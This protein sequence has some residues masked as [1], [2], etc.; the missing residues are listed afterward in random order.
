MVF[1]AVLFLL[2]GGLIFIIILLCKQTKMFV[3]LFI[4]SRKSPMTESYLKLRVLIVGIFAFKNC[5][6]G[7]P[8]LVK[9]ILNSEW[10]NFVKFNL[11]LKILKDILKFIQKYTF[12]F[13]KIENHLKLFKNKLIEEF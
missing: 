12:A 10:I 5:L 2:L 9:I 1:S 8:T 3:Q 6:S 4:N 7:F 11:L 13:T